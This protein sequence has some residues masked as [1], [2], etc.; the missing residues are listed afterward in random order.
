MVVVAVDT[1]EAGAVDLGVQNLCGLKIGRHENGGLEAETS[2]LRGNRVGE[3]AGR[4]APDGLKAERC[5]L[6]RA[7]ETTRSLKLSVGKQTASFLT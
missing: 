4:G 2:G 1:D 7:T 6:A 3:I 5:A